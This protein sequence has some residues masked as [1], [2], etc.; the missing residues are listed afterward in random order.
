MYAERAKQMVPAL[1]D[2]HRMATI[3]MDE[4]THADGRILI[5]GAGGGLETRAFAETHP[6]WTFDAVDPAKAMLD[7]AANTLAAHMDRVR[8]HHGYIDQAPTGPFDAA[9]SLLTLH[10]LQPDARRD[11]AAQVRRRLPSGAPLIVMHMSFPQQCDAERELWIERHVGY[12]VA[13]GI[14][15]EEARKA[16]EAIADKVPVLSPE[17]DCDI[18][19]AAGFS[20]VR[21]FFSTFTF[22]GWVCRA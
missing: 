3:L 6:N 4:H 22:R 12:L 20:E 13:N 10:F 2:V 8:M 16:R 18:L 14:A 9:T 17:Q 19:Y 5:L 1:Q 7:L 21:Q 11:T 15:P